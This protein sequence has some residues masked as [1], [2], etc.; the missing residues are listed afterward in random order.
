MEKTYLFVSV[1]KQVLI[2]TV[3]FSS[4]GLIYSCL[5]WKEK[6]TFMILSKEIFSLQEI[7]LKWNRSRIR[8]QRIFLPVS[9]SP[10]L[11][12]SLSLSLS[13]STLDLRESSFLGSRQGSSKISLVH[14]RQL[15]CA[16]L[17]RNVC[18]RH[19]FPLSRL[20]RWLIRFQM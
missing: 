8:S 17:L 15:L 7:R 13:L 14:L 6:M 19:L 5:A 4:L 16:S 2:P 3:T 11:K 12:L 20:R 1:A 10:S 18:G 9:V